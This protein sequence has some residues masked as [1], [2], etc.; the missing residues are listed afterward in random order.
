[1]LHRRSLVR[2][3]T[4]QAGLVLLALLGLLIAGGVY[5]T[6]VEP[7]WI[8]CRRVALSNRPV[9]R[10]AHVTD[11]HFKGDQAYLRKVVRFLNRSDADV[12]C[13]TGDLVEDPRFL[14]GALAVLSELRKPIFGI[15][16]NHDRWCLESF[17]PIADAFRETGGRWLTDGTARIAGKP[18]EL[19]TAAARAAGSGAQ[20]ADGV[21]RVLLIH[22]PAEL[23]RLAGARFD[24]ILAGHT[25]GGQVRLPL[26]GRFILPYD[27]A[28]CAR[29]LYR[30]TAGPLYV[31]PGIGTFFWNVR[32]A[33]RPEITFIDL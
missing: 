15:P 8:R 5:A 27:P 25:H 12:V 13:F 19:V 32:F 17:E 28:G 21:R 30:T 29:G 10:I 26:I 14:D 24:L 2:R 1:M 18:V 4:A 3:L 11:I 7:R 6:R 22:D 23:G 31:N 20:A 33:C 16:G 9:V